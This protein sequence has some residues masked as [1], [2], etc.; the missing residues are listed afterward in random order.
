MKNINNKVISTSEWIFTKLIMLIPI[1]NI[2]MLI[3]WIFSKKTNINKANWAKANLIMML[4][5]LILFLIIF[6][7]TA[8]IIVNFFDVMFNPKVHI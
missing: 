5:R 1:V 6:F 3:V 2:I 8:V 4:V 7:A